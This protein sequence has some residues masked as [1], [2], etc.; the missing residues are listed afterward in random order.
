VQ[1]YLDSGALLD[2]SPGYAL[3]TP[4]YWHYWQ[5]ESPLLQLLRQR[6]GH[7]AKQFLYQT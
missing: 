1:S 4:L 6:V 3:D 7:T 2:L 5:T